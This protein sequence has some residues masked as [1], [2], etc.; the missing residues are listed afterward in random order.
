MKKVKL[1]LGAALTVAV[2]GGALAFKSHNPIS[3]VYCDNGL[4]I[5]STPVLFNTA[6]P[7]NPTTEPCP[8]QAGKYL[9]S[10]IPGT[11][12]CPDNTT[13]VFPVTPE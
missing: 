2:V 9:I 4:G 5:C 8:D 6:G 10:T 13:T 11:S 1:I 12:A 3:N 7:D